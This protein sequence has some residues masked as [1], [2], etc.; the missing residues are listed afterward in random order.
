V[1][2]ALTYPMSLKQAKIERPDPRILQRIRGSKSLKSVT[3]TFNILMDFG[4][5]TGNSCAVIESDRDRDRLLRNLAYQGL[6][7]R[8][9]DLSSQLRT[10]TVLTLAESY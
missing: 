1:T 4:D 6:T 2:E 10:C 3:L 5:I 7:T 9:R 8:L